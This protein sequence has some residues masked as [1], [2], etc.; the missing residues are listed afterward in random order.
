MADRDKKQISEKL[1][2][3]DGNKA[4][5]KELCNEILAKN[6]TASK[7]RSGDRS[8]LAIATCCAVLA[9]ALIVVLPVA[10]HFGPSDDP[11]D[12]VY[13]FEQSLLRKERIEGLGVLEEQ[14]FEG[15]LVSENNSSG[16]LFACYD[17]DSFV[18]VVQDVWLADDSYLDFGELFIY[19]AEYVAEDIENK[20]YIT[21]KNDD[22]EIKYTVTLSGE[23]NKLE[24][25]FEYYGYKY[26]FDMI[27]DSD[28]VP[29][30]YFD[31]IAN[32]GG[33]NL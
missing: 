19:K 26:Y 24:V 28:D 22:I 3:A 2:A 17:N 21:Y 11:Q 32:R 10:M 31:L 7:R 29:T 25:I 23:G 13:Y 14:Q 15:I 4:K 33:Q 5:T 20:N 1:F 12:Q 9:I 6:G 8:K 18:G 16:M 27:S 30:R